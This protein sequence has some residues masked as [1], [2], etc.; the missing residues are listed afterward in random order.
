MPWRW[1]D[2]LDIYS[3][4]VE[5]SIK[6]KH[7][8][9]P[10]APTDRTLWRDS[11]L[12]QAHLGCTGHSHG[13]NTRTNRCMWW[14]IF[15]CFQALKMLCLYLIGQTCL[16]L[17]FYPHLSSETYSCKYEKLPNTVINAC[18]NIT[19]KM[20]LLKMCGPQIG[21]WLF[22]FWHIASKQLNSLTTIVTLNWLDVAQVT[23]PL[24][25]QEVPGSIPGSGRGFYVWFLS[26]NVA[27]P[28]A[29]LIYLVYLTYCLICDR[30]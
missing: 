23:H 30:F 20:N 12:G 10:W 14:I 27:I 22:T 3:I 25:V 1:N 29:M 17:T 26:Q 19:E 11:V 13:L 8:S 15:F 9:I 5:I 24:W 7:Q 28:F 18:N 6:S 16:H 21:P 4:C 2:C